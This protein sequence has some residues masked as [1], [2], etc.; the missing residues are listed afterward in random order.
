M[1]GLPNVPGGISQVSLEKL[2]LAGQGG[3]GWGLEEGEGISERA[4]TCSDNL[5]QEQVEPGC[6]DSRSGTGRELC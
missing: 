2:G 3:T 4:K 1:W 5:T 6:P